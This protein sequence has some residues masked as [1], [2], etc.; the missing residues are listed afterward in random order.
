MKRTEGKRVCCIFNTPAHYCR[1]IYSLIDKHF[2]CKFIFGDDAPT[3]KKFDTSLLRDCSFVQYRY[4][5]RILFVPGLIKYAFKSYD[6]YIINP[7]T[8]NFSMWLFL[9][10]LRLMPSK[11]VY[12]WT[13]GMYGN[14]SKRQLFFKKMQNVLCDGEFVY[15]DYAISLMKNKGFKAEKLFPIHNSLDYDAQLEL[16]SKTLQSDVYSRHFGNRS[17]K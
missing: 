4:I 16:R 3:V 10:I 8:N 6:N 14:E 15:G 17:L 2:N 7:S 1:P 12:T 5:N 9:L 11:K 13:H